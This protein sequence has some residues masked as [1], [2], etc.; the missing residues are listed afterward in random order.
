MAGEIFISYRRADESRAK[1]LYDRLKEHG[2]EAWYDAHVGA[3]E[4]WRQATAKALERSKIFVL[5]FSKAAS[6]SEDI[7]KELAA[8]TFSKKLVV[9]V[10]IENIQPSG[11]FL[12]ELA[13]RNWIDA[14]RD[15][16]A[17][18]GELAKNLAAVVKKG[19]EAPPELPS[20]RMTPSARPPSRIGLM[21]AG[22][23]LAL[24]LVVGVGAYLM[25]PGPAKPN[26]RFAF[27][28]FDSADDLK[29]AA[30]VANDTMFRTLT[31]DRVD[32]LAPTETLDTKPADRL[33]RAAALGAQYAIIG[34][35]HRAES[36]KLRASVQMIDVPSKRPLWPAEVDA[37]VD[38]VTLLGERAAYQTIPVLHCAADM[39]ATLARD[40]LDTVKLLP[41]ACEAV[42]LWKP[43]N[44]S[45]WRDLASR[46]PE[47]AAIQSSLV[48]L[49]NN[50]RRPGAD[51]PELRE[52]AKAAFARVESTA[53]DSVHAY[54]ARAVL[55]MWD[56]PI[57]F[58]AGETVLLEGLKRWPED[59][60]L[61]YNYAAVL[62]GVG[63]LNESTAPMQ[64]S[65]AADPLSPLKQA[66]LART[67][68]ASG[69]W[70]AEGQKILKRVLDVS[71]FYIAWYILY[72]GLP[73]DKEEG[74]KAI[75]DEAPA[76]VLQDQVD[77]ARTAAQKVIELRK[78]GKK[79]KKVDLGC[80]VAAV[81]RP[82]A[83]YALYAFV[84]DLDS[85][86]AASFP[87][88]PIGETSF[89]FLPSTRAAR[90]DDRFETYAEKQGLVT[91]WKKTGN[92]PDFCATEPAPVCAKLKATAAPAPH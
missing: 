14:Y 11:T 91:Y 13:S 7:A 50:S 25:K 6:E 86:F 63:R 44:L 89:M 46:A 79:E 32:T 54:R 40:D 52:E 1:L 23:A 47:S 64:S 68:A 73:L 90:L 74:A 82:D 20:G 77:C 78:V 83:A 10:R 51:T 19:G 48:S 4:D 66:Y 81:I 8:A 36:G 80:D 57:D 5:L 85:A 2:V 49:L 3:G 53:P 21:V 56:T 88:L 87:R 70:P 27:F 35:I 55:A 30:S 15:T 9:P 37:P 12:Y 39:R 76:G 42:T 61:N 41:G 28:G 22:G 24:A 45:L 43:V 60:W 38:S 59:S 62:R 33:A 34:E 16:D 65:A 71:Q 72:A 17:K 18:L 84:G 29:S 67:I 69:Q 26:E 92:L 75:M 31:L 58:A